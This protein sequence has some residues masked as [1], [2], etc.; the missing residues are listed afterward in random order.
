MLH[1]PAAT[2]KDAAF[3]QVRNGYAVR[4]DRWR[5]IEWD[6]GRAGDA[7]L[8]H[9]ARSGRDDEPGERCPACGHGERPPRAPRGISAMIPKNGSEAS[10]Q[11]AER[12]PRRGRRT[13][14]TRRPLRGRKTKTASKAERTKTCFI[15][16]DIGFRRCSEADPFR[17]G[18]V[19]AGGRSQTSERGAIRPVPSDLDRERAPR[20]AGRASHR[21]NSFPVGRSPCGTTTTTVGG[22]W[23]GSRSWRSRG[24]TAA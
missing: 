19:P 2:V 8:R 14:A 5:Y 22:P 7:A 4:T 13:F 17:A 24:P 21:A 23:R 18:R 3:T 15:C 20:V 10:P 16:N 6:G 9:G 11:T 12:R 1:D